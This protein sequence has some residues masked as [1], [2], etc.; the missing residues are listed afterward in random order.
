MHVMQ[1]SRLKQI[2]LLFVKRHVFKRIYF[3]Y[4]SEP[5]ATLVVGGGGGKSR[6]WEGT[7]TMIGV[8]LCVVLVACT[9]AF[10]CHHRI[11]HRKDKAKQLAANQALLVNG[12]VKCSHQ[13]RFSTILSIKVLKTYTS[14][15]IKKARLPCWP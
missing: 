12:N 13:S 2:S 9:V 5:N 4:F 15:W 10:V 11:T 3:K 1:K 8:A 14:T 7:V 6:Q